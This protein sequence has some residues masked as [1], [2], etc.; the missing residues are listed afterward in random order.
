MRLGRWPSASGR[1]SDPRGTPAV[2]E[3]AL[4]WWERGWAMAAL[5][6]LAALPLLWPAIPPLVDLPGHMA[7]YKAQLDLAGSPELQQFY[8]LKWSLIGN[9]GVNLAVV[10]LAKL[11][12]LEPAVKIVIL[13]IPPVTV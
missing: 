11:V 1:S 13:L 3:R 4:N 5:A 12:G 2:M 10:P 9:L 7:E 8:T 6:L